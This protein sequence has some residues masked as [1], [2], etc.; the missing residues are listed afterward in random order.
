MEISK[1][2]GIHS[3]GVF[4]S[5]QKRGQREKIVR[6]TEDLFVLG[7]KRKGNSIHRKIG[8][9]IKRKYDRINTSRTGQMIQSNVYN[10][11]TSLKMEKNS[12][13]ERTEQG[14]TNNSF[15]EEWN[16]LSEGFNKERRLGNKLRFKIIL[17]TPNSISTTQTIPCI[18][19]NWESL[20]IQSNA[21][22]NATVPNLL[23]TSTSNGSNEDTERVKHKNFEL[24]RRSAPPTLEQRKIARIHID[25]NENLRNIWMD[26]SLREMRN[27]TKTTDQ[28]PSVDLGLEKDV[29]K[30]DRPKETRIT[31]FIKEIFQPNRETSPDQDQVSSINIRQTEF[32]KSPIRRSFSLPKVNGLSKDESIEEQRMEREYD[33]TQGNL[34]RAL[35]MARSGSKELRDDIRSENSRGNDGIGRISKGMGSDSG[36]VNRRYFSPTWRIEQGKE[37]MDKQQEGDGTYILRSIPQLISLQ[38]AANQSDPHQVR[39]LYCSISFIKTKSWGNSSCGS[40]EN[41]KAMSATE[42]TNTDS[43]YSG[44]IEQDNR[45]TKQVKYSGRLFNEER[46]FHIPMLS[47][48]DNTNSG[49]VRNRGKQTRGQ[50]RGNRRG[51][52]RGKMVERIFQTMEGR[53]LLDL[54]INSEDWKSPEHLGEVQTKVNHYSTLV[55]R[56][57]MVHVLT[58]RY[59]QI[60]YSWREH[61]DS[62][63]GEE[64]DEE[65][66]HV[67]TRKNRDIPHEPRVDQGR[68]ILTEFLDNINMTKE[69]QKMKIEGQKFNTQKKYLQTM[70]VTRKTKPSS[71]KY[72]VSILNTMLSL[73]FGTVHVY[74]TA[75]KLITQAISNHQ[76]NNPR[77]G[78]T[79][80]INQLF[81]HWRERPE[82]KLLSNKQLQ[83]KLASLLISL[84]FVT[85]EE[86]ANINLSVPIIDDQEQRAAVCIPPKQSVQ[87]ERYDVTKTDEPKMCPIEAFF[88]WLP[89]LRQHFQQSPTNFIYLFWTGNWKRAEQRYINTR[90]ERLVQTLGV[91]NAAANSIRHASSTE[92]TAE[93]FDGRT[94]NCFTHHTPDSKMNKKFYVFAVNKEQD[95]IASAVVRNHGE[96]QATQII[97]KQRGDARVFDGDELQLSPQGD[98]L[99]LSPQETLASPLSTPIISSQPIVEAESPNDHESAKAQKSQMQKDD[100]D[101]KPQE[102]AQNSSMTND[103]DRATTAEAQ[104]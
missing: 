43:T 37:E 50:I 10:S 100:Q 54:L 101:V 9:R 33:S 61:S 75:Q 19:S 27:R 2:S 66:G 55:A 71:A 32:S 99:Q 7:L 44:K 14:G 84:C 87:R 59:Q 74:A 34:P 48:A 85:T 42:N 103:S 36:T 15:K 21:I 76:I 60:H 4:L 23:R 72:H 98:D 28:L 63:P 13:C 30:D 29:H 80:D 104:K 77:Y 93:S 62:E 70:G 82:S 83:I 31:L 6:E 17:S 56:S 24:R 12:G 8:R 73:I 45:R 1:R 96:K 18:R 35:L 49:L 58:N 69:T 39:Q 79:W 92:L 16:R 86:M 11:E 64:D 81:E 97:S 95:S 78:S 41:S 26:N 91:Q 3:I 25:N 5:I 65:E 67:I 68:R 38:R 57:N 40:E 88:V 102:E 90:L 51:I 47:V 94:I 89:I 20:L 22:R 46:D 53:Y 52:G